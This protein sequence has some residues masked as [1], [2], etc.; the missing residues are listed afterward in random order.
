[1]TWYATMLCEFARQMQIMGRRALIGSFAT[2]NPRME[3]WPYYVPALRACRYYG[4][5]HARHCYGPIDR[6]NSLRYRD[7][8]IE[9]A[10]LGFPH[11][12]TIISE[13]GADVTKNLFGDIIYKPWREQFGDDITSYFDEWC[14]PFINEINKDEDIIGAT[15]FTVGDGHAYD[16]WHKFDVSGTGIIDLMRSRLGEISVKDKIMAE[17][18]TTEGDGTAVAVLSMGTNQNALVRVRGLIARWMRE[19]GYMLSGVTPAIVLALPEAGYR[20]MLFD[21]PGSTTPQF[22]KPV[23]DMD[24]H[25]A[26]TDTDGVV[27]YRVNPPTREP[28]WLL[29][30]HVTPKA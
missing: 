16:T 15:L 1:M 21:R 6:W 8:A 26:F 10:K 20:V 22:W 23:W 19:L 18:V 11:V 9:F 17:T 7:D 13:C 30:A 14:I 25:E 2:G 4:A 12:P 28:M 24:V 3:L 27:W 5:I 29:K